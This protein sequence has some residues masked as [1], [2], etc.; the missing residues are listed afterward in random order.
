MIQR[1]LTGVT[2]LVPTYDQG[3]ACFRD[4]LGFEVVE[5]T[6][7]GGGKRWLVVAAGAAAEVRLILAEPGNE[8]QKRAL[9]QQTGDRVGFF[10]R[11]DDFDSD[12]S[13]FSSMGIAFLEAPRDEPYGRVAV[14]RD[15]FGNLWDPIQ[16]SPDP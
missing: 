14:F 8:T 5:D 15:D 4:K 11:T 1:S 10:L 7:L 3:L 12:Y 13:A 6:D 2:L 9:G 16:T